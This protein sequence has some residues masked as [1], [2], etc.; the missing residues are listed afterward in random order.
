M[1]EPHHA[2]K[3]IRTIGRPEFYRSIYTKRQSLFTAVLYDKNISLFHVQQKQNGRKNNNFVSYRKK[4]EKQQQYTRQDK[5]M[6]MKSRRSITR[7]AE[8]LRVYTVKT[9]IRDKQHKART[10]Y[11]FRFVVC[12]PVLS[13][14]PAH[15]GR[16]SQSTP[17]GR[18][19]R[20]KKTY[21]L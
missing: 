14:R 4:Q 18:H 16:V 5:K 10:Y 12:T 3:G 8:Q 1:F 13:S 19:G 2:S 7:R 21:T 11:A 15:S 6:K 20:T 9:L 17:C